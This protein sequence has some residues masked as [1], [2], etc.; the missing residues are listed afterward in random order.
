MI[1]DSKELKYDEEN[2]IHSTS[3]TV[4][5]LEEQSLIVHIKSM[6]RPSCVVFDFFEAEEP[7]NRIK[8]CEVPDCF[9][10]EC[11]HKQLVYKVKCS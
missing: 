4:H 5:L 11:N 3:S 10:A 6:T 8:E 1:M 9:K 7:H 2:L